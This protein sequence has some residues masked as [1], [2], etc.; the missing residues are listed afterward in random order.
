MA[1][2][3]RWPEDAASVIPLPTDAKNFDF[4]INSEDI[5]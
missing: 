5:I 3:F 4:I 1:T 2:E